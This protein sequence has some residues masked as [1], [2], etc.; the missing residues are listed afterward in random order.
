MEQFEPRPLPTIFKF[1]HISWVLAYY[2]WLHEWKVL[3]ELLSKDT[4]K[5]WKDNLNAFINWG[6]NLKAHLRIEYRPEKSEK[7]ISN[8]E[9]NYKFIDCFYVDSYWLKLFISKI[10]KGWFSNNVIFVSPY[11][12]FIDG[13]LNEEAYKYLDPWDSRFYKILICTEEQASK[14]ISAIKCPNFKEKSDHLLNERILNSLWFRESSLYS[15]FLFKN[16]GVYKYKKL[17]N[18]IYD[19]NKN[20]RLKKFENSCTI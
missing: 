17:F 10:N 4:S 9:L 12:Y 18:K 2:G 13:I 15:I 5:I 11:D 8:L 3:M 1:S 20:H 6:E 19:L 14:K 7:L 16:Q